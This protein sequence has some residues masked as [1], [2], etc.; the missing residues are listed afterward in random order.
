MARE[1]KRDRIKDK[2]VFVK[3]HQAYREIIAVCDSELLGKRF[4]EGNLQLEINKH[5]Y[6]GE[7]MSESQ[8]LE[9]LNEKAEEDACFNFVGKLAVELGAKAGIVDMDRVIKIQGVPH[10]MGLL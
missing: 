9:L 4:E 5:F 2:K 1:N 3:I 10:A 8:A 7:E 6:G